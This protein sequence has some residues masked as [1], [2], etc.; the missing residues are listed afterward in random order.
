[1]T[2]YYPL[3]CVHLLFA[4]VIMTSLRKELIVEGHVS[5]TASSALSKLMEDGV[6][7]LEDMKD[8]IDKKNFHHH[9]ERKIETFRMTAD[10]LDEFKQNIT[11]AIRDVV[12]SELCEVLFRDHARSDFLKFGDNSTEVSANAFSVAM[13]FDEEL[14]AT[15]L[16]ACKAACISLEKRPNLIELFEAYKQKIP[17]PSTEIVLLENEVENQSVSERSTESP[18]VMFNRE[19]KVSVENKRFARK[20]SAPANK[21][22]K[23]LKKAKVVE[24]PVK[25]PVEYVYGGIITINDPVDGHE[26]TLR[27]TK[28]KELKPGEINMKYAK[29]L[30]LRG[31]CVNYHVPLN[32]RH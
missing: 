1:L 31:L 18:R 2:Y 8:F 4:L 5:Q 13:P 27:I 9:V 21:K 22:K 32:K 17:T 16:S 30:T 29:E 14:G 7:T 15:L 10:E 24:M 12:E 20:R 3:C 6:I 23:E 11:P 28:R 19:N 26:R 25:Q